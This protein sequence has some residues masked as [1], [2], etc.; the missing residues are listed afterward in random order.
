MPFDDGSSWQEALALGTVG[1]ESVMDTHT[2]E[3]RMD[4]QC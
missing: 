1:T 2:S 3:K 4:E